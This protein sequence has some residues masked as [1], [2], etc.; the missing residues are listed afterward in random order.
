MLI[1]CLGFLLV[2]CFVFCLVH[3]CINKREL[4]KN[5]PDAIEIHVSLSLMHEH[6]CGIFFF[7]SVEVEGERGGG[8][9][10][11]RGGGG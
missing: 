9:G 1:M 11:E 6:T 2:L 8:R 5:D 10:A 7:G 3:G 4:C